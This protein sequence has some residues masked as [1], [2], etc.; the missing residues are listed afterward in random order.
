MNITKEMDLLKGQIVITDPLYLKDD[1]SFDDDQTEAMQHEVAK[2]FE[3]FFG[4]RESGSDELKLSLLIDGKDLTTQGAYLMIELAI[5]KID[6]DAIQKHGS[7]SPH[8]AVV[9]YDTKDLVILNPDEERFI[10]FLFALEGIFHFGDG[11]SMIDATIS[12]HFIHGEQ[13][14]NDRYQRQFNEKYSLFDDP[15]LFKIE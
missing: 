13:W 14:E 9:F 15:K 5:P 8:S 10:D 3:S 4:K 1:F 12:E 6:K 2:V 7:V 11:I